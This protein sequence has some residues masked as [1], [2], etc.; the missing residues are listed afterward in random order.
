MSNDVCSV[1][2][3]I[4]MRGFRVIFRVIVIALADFVLERSTARIAH[5]TMGI[6]QILDL[7]TATFTLCSSSKELFIEITLSKVKTQKSDQISEAKREQ[8]NEL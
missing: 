2:R 7:K 4:G 8:S 6:Y 3:V 1:G 5:E